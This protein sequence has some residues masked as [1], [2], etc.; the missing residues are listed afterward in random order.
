MLE[1]LTLP[2]SPATDSQAVA[3][4]IV[5]GQGSRPGLFNGPAAL[6]V[7]SDGRVL[8]LEQG[9]SRIQAVDVN[10]NPVYC[11]SRPSVGSA[12]ASALSG[13]D[14]G[15]VSTS[16][17]S[18]FSDAGCPLSS[19]WRVQDGSNIY[20]LAAS[21]SGITVTWSG[22]ALS[23]TWTITDSST[24]SAQVFTCTLDGANI[25]VANS[26]GVTLFSVPAADLST[27]NS[28]A[29]AADIYSGLST[30]SITLVA[31]VSV[32]GNGLSLS[33][34]DVDSLC[35]GQV[36]PDLASSL[37]ARGITLSN[38]ATVSSNITVQVNTAGSQWTITD[39]AGPSTYQITNQ[40]GAGAIVQLV[41]FVPPHPGPGKAAMTYK[42]I[43]TELKGYIYTLGYTGDGT[44]VTDFLLDIYQPDG[45]F[46]ARTGG[47]NAGCMTVDMWR[48]V[49]T[50]NFES[51]LGPGDRTE[52]SVS[53]WTP[54]TY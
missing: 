38:S 19:L 25:D 24:P 20:Q 3:A 26:S 15:L 31:P 2:S 28:G 7:T 12:P 50:L 51:F 53:T 49:F 39:P 46:L 41:P 36:P 13:L 18:V 27:L 52:P 44:A 11:F 42:S 23:N 48:N 21:S 1:V 40:S 35:Q 8:V 43:G 34:S 37:S 22:S 45:Q 32:T 10:G 9:N 29:V 16:L 14:Q 4:V 54:S 5:G 33:S 17:R 47:M 30:Q 6:I